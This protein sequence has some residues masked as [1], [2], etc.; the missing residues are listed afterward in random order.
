[1]N[2]H[3]R[4]DS[5]L[6][7][8]AR[9]EL[10][11]KA[12]FGD[13]RDGMEA[14]EAW[15]K[16]VNLD[17]EFDRGS[18]RLMPLLYQNVQRL[19]LRDPLMGR[20]KGIYRMAWY[21][22]HQLFHRTL[23]VVARLAAEG[24]PTLLVKGVPLVVGYYR[25]HAVRPMAD[26]DLVVRTTHV[27]KSIDILEAAGWKRNERASDEDVFYRHSMQFLH[28]DR[29]ELDLHWH[30]LFEA[31]TEQAD[32]HFWSASRALEVEGVKTRQLCPTDMLLHIVVH[33]IRWNP[34]PPIRWI[35]DAVI[36]LRTAGKDI[37]WHRLVTSARAMKLT[38]RLHLGLRYLADRGF[39]DMP[40]ETLDA[41]R[42]SPTTMV[43]RIENTVALHDRDAM[44]EHLLLKNWVIFADY[45]RRDSENGPIGFLI[46]LSH[47]LRYRLDMKGRSEILPALVKGMARRIARRVHGG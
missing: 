40:R 12:A 17:D 25:N 24:I 43:E 19:G 6:F 29:G 9:Q 26:L 31:C 2:R 15:R 21:E 45:C 34:E 22:N 14:F 20:L 23:P 10:V 1:M 36:I 39:V 46:G 47:Y 32:D 13:G 35:P 3:A 18:F 4:H 11:L 41:L 30:L 44:Y 5:Q 28:P 42:G 38:H 27:R 33:G 16:G 8:S 7:P 37:D